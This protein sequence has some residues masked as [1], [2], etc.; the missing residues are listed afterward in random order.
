LSTP[1]HSASGIRTLLALASLIVVIAGLKAA[2]AIVVPLLVAMF[3]AM[4]ATPPMLWLRDRHLPIGIALGL[5]VILLI[6]VVAIVGS[7][8]GSSINELS[9]AL[10]VYE[11]KLRLSLDITVNYLRE[12]S[13]DLPT[14]GVAEW[15][16][17]KAAAQFFGRLL[18]GFGGILSDSLLII[19]MVFFLLLEATVIPAKLRF[20][21]PDPEETLTNFSGFMDALKSYLAIKT[22]TSML[23]GVLVS[24]WLTILNVEF[25][26]LWGSIAFFL[27]FVP[28]IGSLIAA[29]PVVILALLDV[30]L[31]SASL[32]ALGY[33]VINVIVGNLLEPRFMG[34]GLN[35]ST[36]VVFLSLMFWGW[37]FGPVGMF[38][39]VPLTMLVKIALEYS[40]RSRWLAVLLSA[41]VPQ[42]EDDGDRPNR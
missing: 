17:P 38:L 26:L 30:G 35:L 21:L 19:F 20:I 16:D 7:L 1:L 32:I 5:I 27:N 40:P 39:S 3:L 13:I 8:I 41:N 2:S 28:I 15:V 18:A 36:L 10:P 37:V 4:L 6:S 22:G 42:L 31:G 29:I 33:L 23:T 34:R 9:G 12:R 14:S 11:Q 25:A 24:V